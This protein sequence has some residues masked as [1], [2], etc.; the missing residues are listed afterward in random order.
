MKNLLKRNDEVLWAAS[1]GTEPQKKATV[2]E[3]TLLDYK[4]AKDDGVEVEQINWELVPEW[5][6]VTLDNGHW[7]YG[8]QL[9]PLH[10]EVESV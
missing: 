10:F 9:E 7:A 2:T 5:V 3:I 8:Y 4:G 1:W 6:V